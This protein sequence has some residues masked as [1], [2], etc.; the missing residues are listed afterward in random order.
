MLARSSAG[1]VLEDD[2]ILTVPPVVLPHAIIGTPLDLAN[3]A[4]LSTAT[5]N[6][7]FIF[8]TGI[9]RTGIGALSIANCPI[10]AR[11]LWHLTGL[12]SYSFSGTLSVA[13]LDRVYITTIDSSTNL[14]IL[15]LKHRC[16]NNMNSD[17]SFEFWLILPEP[18]PRLVVQLDA[19]VALDFA[20]IDLSLVANKI[21]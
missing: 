15:F 18:G 9:V 21:W 20:S 14:Q 8:S 4:V 10:F 7:S 2:G 19:T 5:L 3:A 11:G 16:A 1:A 12:F 6:Q 13:T 17:A